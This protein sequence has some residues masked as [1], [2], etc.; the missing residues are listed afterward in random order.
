[1]SFLRYESCKDSGVEWLGEVPEHWGR[2]DRRSQPRHPP[3]AR[4]S[5]R[6]DFRRRHRQ[7]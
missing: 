1:M 5:H 3:P 2:P 6:P 7:D 4:T